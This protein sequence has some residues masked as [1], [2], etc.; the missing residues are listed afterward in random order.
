L[1]A[2]ISAAPFGAIPALSATRRDVVTRLKNTASSV[3]GG[4]RTARSVSLLLT[5]EVGLALVLLLGAAGVKDVLSQSVKYVLSMNTEARA[6]CLRSP[7]LQD[8]VRL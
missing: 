3:A 5:A 7:A 6:T 4:R 8:T 2:I 1:L